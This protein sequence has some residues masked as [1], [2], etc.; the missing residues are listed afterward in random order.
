[1]KQP[2][3]PMA[4]SCD[5]SMDNGQDHWQKPNYMQLTFVLKPCGIR[6]QGGKGTQILSQISKER[7]YEIL[8]ICEA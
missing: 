4:E 7:D 1:M 6:E 3:S 5:A 2:V 8:Q